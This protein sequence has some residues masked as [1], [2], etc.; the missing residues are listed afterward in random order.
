M[1]Q[2]INQI[3]FLKSKCIKFFLLISLLLIAIPTYAGGPEFM[4][5]MDAISHSDQAHAQ[6]IL[7]N[8][9]KFSKINLNE[10]AANGWSPL[11]LAA[12]KGNSQ[13]VELLLNTKKAAKIGASRTL[14]SDRSRTAYRTRLGHFDGVISDRSTKGIEPV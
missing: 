5:L 2:L 4:E 3:L 8:P 13:I 10:K 14:K 7:G 1:S 6:A 12:A 11:G 9:E